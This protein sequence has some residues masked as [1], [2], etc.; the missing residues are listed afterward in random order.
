MHFLTVLAAEVQEAAQYNSGIIQKRCKRTSN[1]GANIGERV[2]ITCETLS[3][4]TRALLAFDLVTQ[5]HALV[6][7]NHIF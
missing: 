2:V 7:L 1:I 6:Q 5:A 4:T 3:E